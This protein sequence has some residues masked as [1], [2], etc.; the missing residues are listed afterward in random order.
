MGSGVWVSLRRG[1][2]RTLGVTLAALCSHLPGIS[3]YSPFVGLEFDLLLG[4]Q[5]DHAMLGHQHR[6]A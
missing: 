5:L 2:S 4:A 1:Q 3:E 6:L